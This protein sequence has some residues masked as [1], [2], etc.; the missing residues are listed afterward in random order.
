MIFVGNE[1]FRRVKP[2]IYGKEDLLLRDIKRLCE[3]NSIE[4]SII[5]IVRTLKRK[6]IDT[7]PEEISFYPNGKYL[8]IYSNDTNP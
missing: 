7:F 8:I 4:E 6:I 1:C 3:K 2:I 5:T